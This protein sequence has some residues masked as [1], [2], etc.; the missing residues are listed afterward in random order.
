MMTKYEY[1]RAISDLCYEL[2]GI[3]KMLDNKP[4]E[5]FYMN[6]SR[7]YDQKIFRLTVE[8]AN[9]PAE[10]Y[11]IKRLQDFENFKTKKRGSLCSQLS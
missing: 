11:Q 7:S 6:A 5:T 1:Y 8:Q 2:S 3:F 10:S 4:L 9:T